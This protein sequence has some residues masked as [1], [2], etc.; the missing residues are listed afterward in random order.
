MLSATG[1]LKLI[2]FGTAK[3]INEEVKNTEMY[4]R[5]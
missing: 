1:H 4:K 2:D 3:F 5:L